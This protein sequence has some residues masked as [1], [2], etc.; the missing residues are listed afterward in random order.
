MYIKQ[1][2]ADN[3]QSLQHEVIDLPPTGLV[4][5]TGQNSNGKSIIVKTLRIMLSGLL[6]KPRKRSSLVNRHSSFA[7][8]TFIRS[9]GVELL[10][11]ISTAANV[12]YVKLSRPGEEPIVRYL[13]DKSYMDLIYAFGWHYDST[14]GIS[15][16]LAEEEE[17]LLFYKT[18]NKVNFTVTETAT[19]DTTANKISDNLEMTLKTAR[20]TRDKWTRDAQAYMTAR[21]QLTTEDVVPLQ[22]KLQRLEYI[23]RCLDTIYFPTIPDIKFVPKVHY[24]DI[25]YPTIPEV[26][27]PRI[28]DL[29]VNIPDITQTIKDLTSLREHKCPTCGRGFDCDC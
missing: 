7:E 10:T 6:N 14:S 23:Y 27:Y 3:L 18:P 13:A 17:A 20:D 21:A 15:L 28:I 4:V 9:D 19:T 5:F 22:E 11:H 24:V 29:C 8:L 26:K 16:N 2:I 25:K 1:I 12:T